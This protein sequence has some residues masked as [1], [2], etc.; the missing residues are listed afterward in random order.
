MRPRLKKMIFIAPLAMLGMLLLITLGGEIVLQLWNWLLPSLFG[1]RQITFL[2]YTPS[3]ARAHARAL[4]EHDARGA[5]TI[6][7][8]HART[9]GLRPTHRR[10]QGAMNLC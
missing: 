7:A 4:R 6:P 10:E 9:L 1:W 8:G 5:G 3:H 2:Q